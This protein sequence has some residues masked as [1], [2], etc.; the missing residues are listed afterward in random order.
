MPYHQFLEITSAT[1]SAMTSDFCEIK[2][3]PKDMCV[4]NVQ[5]GHTIHG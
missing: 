5:C 2:F 3:C 1:G 4:V